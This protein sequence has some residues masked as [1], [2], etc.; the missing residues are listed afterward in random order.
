[1]IMTVEE[2]RSYITTSQSGE[3]LELKLQGLTSYIKK[4]TNNNFKD[5]YPV[6]IK[7]GVVELFR[8]EEQYRDKLGISSETISRHS[9]SYNSNMQLEGTYP[10]EL[11]N[12]LKPYMKARF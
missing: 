7:M 10:K 9:I 5:G 12:F 3:V 11:L 4:K 2:L 8:W 6:D 1:M